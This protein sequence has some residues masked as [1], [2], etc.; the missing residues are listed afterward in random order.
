MNNGNP[1]D[2]WKPGDIAFFNDVDRTELSNLITVVAEVDGEFVRIGGRYG[3]TLWVNGTDPRLA[4]LALDPNRP[5]N[6]SK[7]AAAVLRKPPW[8]NV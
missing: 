3:T 4:R 8:N 1:H 2:D 7:A 6:I 5:I